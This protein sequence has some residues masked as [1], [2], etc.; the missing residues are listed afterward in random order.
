MDQ[1][2]LRTKNKALH[3]KD[4]WMCQ[5]NDEE[6]DSPALWIALLHQYIGFWTTWKNKTKID[7][8]QQ[9]ITVLT[10]KVQIKKQKQK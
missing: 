1:R 7:W 2:H 4:D 10:P 6:N 9:Q 3:P 5:E 8:L